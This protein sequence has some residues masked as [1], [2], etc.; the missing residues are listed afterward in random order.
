MKAEAAEMRAKAAARLSADEIQAVRLAALMVLRESG[1]ARRVIIDY[2][3]LLAEADGMLRGQRSGFV[4]DE[5]PA[6]AP[7]TLTA[8]EAKR[9]DQEIESHIGRLRQ[10]VKAPEGQAA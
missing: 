2:D 7:T 4:A 1:R 5:A 10:K 6:P 9:V 8:A 3:A